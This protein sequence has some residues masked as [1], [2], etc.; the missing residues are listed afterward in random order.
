MSLNFATSSLLTVEFDLHD[1]NRSHFHAEVL[2][3]KIKWSVACRRNPKSQLPLRPFGK[4][5][6]SVTRRS[7]RVM[8][9]VLRQE[10]SLV[11]EDVRRFGDYLKMDVLD[12]LHVF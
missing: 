4:F 12:G 11:K 10:D 7:T 2:F 6:C 8:P 9:L 3:A 1:S 5:T